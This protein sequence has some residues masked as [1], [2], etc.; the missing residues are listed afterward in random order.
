MS[1]SSDI[2]NSYLLEVP[3]EGTASINPLHADENI[4][5]HVSLE[6]IFV[7]VLKQQKAINI[8]RK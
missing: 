6:C 3:T 5:V 1:A 7:D 4:P 8:E 2:G